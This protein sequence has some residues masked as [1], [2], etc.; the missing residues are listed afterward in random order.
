MNHTKEHDS[1]GTIVGY[2]PAQDDDSS[3]D[4]T[5]EL[6]DIPQYSVVELVINRYVLPS[7]CFCT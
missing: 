1:K 6:T 7:G 5:L 3:R 4:C 2:I